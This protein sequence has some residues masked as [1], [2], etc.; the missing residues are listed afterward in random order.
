M[1]CKNFLLLTVAL[2]CS[3]TTMS[4]TRFSSVKMQPKSLVRPV[5]QAQS[6]EDAVDYKK[7]IQNTALWVGAAGAFAGGIAAYKG[8]DAAIEFCSGYALEQCLSVDNLFVFLVLFDYFKV[9]RENQGKVLS[10]GILGGTFLYHP[11]S[12]ITS[13]NGHYY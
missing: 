13:S 3:C 12:C 8:T 4:F 2:L 9:K 7:D 1:Q 11:I 6:A 10:Y 5:L